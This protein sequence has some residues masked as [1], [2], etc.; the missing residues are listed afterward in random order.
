MRSKMLF[1]MVL[2]F[3]MGVSA[4]WADPPSA[5]PPDPYL[6]AEGFQFGKVYDQDFPNEHVDPLSGNLILNYSLA[7]FPG[8]GGF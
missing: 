5:T 6:E 8:P 1:G 3:L 4:A 7:D 2:I